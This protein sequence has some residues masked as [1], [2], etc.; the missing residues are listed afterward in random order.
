MILRYCLFYR[1]LLQKR[2]TILKEPTNRSVESWDGVAIN[3]E[4][5]WLIHLDRVSILQHIQSF[6]WTSLT[7]NSILYR[8]LA[9]LLWG[10][11]D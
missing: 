3:H 11:Y 7:S 4:M 6:V 2:P 5:R 1:A 9:S 8:V 10:G